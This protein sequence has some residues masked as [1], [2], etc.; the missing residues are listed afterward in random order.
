MHARILVDGEG[1]RDLEVVIVPHGGTARDVVIAVGKKTGIST[2]EGV[3]FIEDVDEPVDLDFVI[4]NL[5]PHHVHH[6]HRARSIA[7][8]VFYQ[9]L[10]KVKAF[11]PSTRVQVI[12]EWAVGPEGFKIDPAIAPEMEL[13]L[14]GQT[15]ELSKQAHIG[16]YVQHPKNEL[17][18]DLIR[19]IVPNGSEGM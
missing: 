14:H 2:E 6:V 16:R 7:T 18:L 17:A 19:G 5:K 12:L 4:E 11:S 3:L 15:V 1:L 10:T 9:G 13:T 8:S